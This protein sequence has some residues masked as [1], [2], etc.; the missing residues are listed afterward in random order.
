[1][2]IEGKNMKMYKKRVIVENRMDVE[3]KR[4]MEN[5][6]IMGMDAEMK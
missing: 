3:G 6:E 2:G 1:V 5:K 4:I